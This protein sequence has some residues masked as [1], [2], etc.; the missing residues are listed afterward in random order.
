MKTDR[1]QAV[2]YFLVAVIASLV[3]WL[4]V[5]TVRGSFT[6]PISV[7]SEVMPN[8][9]TS[10]TTTASSSTTAAQEVDESQLSQAVLGLIDAYFTR[11]PDDDSASYLARLSP[12][13]SQAFVDQL[14]IDW[15][16]EE[17]FLSMSRAGIV[18]RPSLDDSDLAI[19]YDEQVPVTVWVEAKLDLVEIRPDGTREVVREGIV[20]AAAWSMTDGTWRV[21]PSLPR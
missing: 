21:S 14:D 15:L 2:F 7:P 1:R 10:T 5:D 11:L 6:E 8:E 18:M 3:V 19:A 20:F 4:V 9:A 13:A 12:Y 17:P 16:E